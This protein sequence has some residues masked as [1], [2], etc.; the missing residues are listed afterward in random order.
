M[1]QWWYNWITNLSGD[2]RTLPPPDML[3]TEPFGTPR[4]DEEGSSAASVVVDPASGATI[5]SKDAVEVLYKY[6]ARLAATS[7][8][9]GPLL[10][11]EDVQGKVRCVVSL[12]GGG[13]LAAF[14]GPRCASKADARRLAAFQVCQEL[15]RLRL[16]ETQDFP[17][18]VFVPLPDIQVEEQDPHIS[19]NASK[20][21]NKSGSLYNH[22]G[23]TMYRR[24]TNGFWRRTLDAP[25]GRL[26][27]TVVMISDAPSTR[28]GP[29]FYR[30]PYRVLCILARLPLPSIPPMKLHFPDADRTVSF[31][32]CAEL[33]VT[34]EQLDVI[35]GFTLHLCR[36][37]SHRPLDCERDSAGCLFA[38]LVSTWSE[39]HLPED[40][41]WP[42]PPLE[43]FLDWDEMQRVADGREETPDL[44]ELEDVVLRDMTAEG[45][46]LFLP[47]K[48]RPDLTPLSA[49]EDIPVSITFNF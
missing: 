36:A 11:Y 37:L 1:P 44:G 10:S 47:S 17:P 43:P 9:S 26:Y 23:T 24:R 35:F 8:V 21:K 39:Q 18:P 2:T 25:S 28:P 6:G 32:R 40:T 49:A 45:V 33:A 20:G 12:P 13:P 3:N 4:S 29:D 48:V 14:A 34:E 19:T 38:P 31:K 7:H 15:Q 46:S 42:F 5:T 16:L 41:T 30:G 22:H 27:P